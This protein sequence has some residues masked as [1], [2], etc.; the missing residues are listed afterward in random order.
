VVR[1]VDAYRGAQ[2]ASTSTGKAPADLES[3][4]QTLAALC[5]RG[6]AAHPEVAVEDEVFA[7]HLGRCGAAVEGAGAAD[8]HAEDLFLCCAGLLGEAAAVHALRGRYRA[9]LA[10]YVR[11]IEAAPAF[12]DE[13]EQRLWDS[14]LVGS[15][16]AAPK[17][18]SYS[19]KGPLA[20]WVGVAA[21]RI[22][23]MIRRSE[24]AEK[25]ALDNVAVEARLIGAD[26]EL[27]FVKDHLR[28]PFQRAIE[29]AFKTLDDRQRMIYSLHLV[30]GLTIERIGVMYGVRHST[31]SRWMAS[32][33]AAIVAEAQRLL[34]E[35]MDVSAEE[36]DSLARLL[37]SQLD[38]SISLVLR[39][40][41]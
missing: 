25:R 29:E 3:V 10:T 2:G 8:V 11:P 5:A 20:A 39:K 7:A 12:L 40:S 32:A 17:L 6:R 35:E 4:G 30:D 28:E 37:A 41:A 18:Q 14:V 22:A 24:A 13:V 31:V 38:L 23:L 1:L 34:R 16:S 33:R 27:A 36:F 19:G 9:V 15:A 26:P 21:Q